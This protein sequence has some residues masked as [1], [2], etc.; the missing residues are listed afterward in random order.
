[1]E[2][3][4]KRQTRSLMHA[5]EAIEAQRDKLKKVNK[6]KNK[7]FSLV[8]HDLKNPLQQM[9]GLLNLLE[10]QML[11]S[12]KGVILTRTMK[13]GL[14]QNITVIERLLQWSYQQ[15]DGIQ[16][17]KEQFDIEELFHEVNHELKL[18]QESKHLTIDAR[19][20][21]TALTADKDMMKVVIRNLLSNAIKFSHEEGHIHVYTKRGKRV[22]LTI[23]DQGIGMNPQWYESLIQSGEPVSTPGTKGEKGKGF[24]LLITK[25]FVEM[26]GGTMACKSEDGSGT[27]FEVSFPA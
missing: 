27:V 11:S 7:L 3:E 17:K 1:L 2:E 15:L 4:V 13:I 19:F 25:D 9:V 26:N 10:N 24:G 21:A 18:A 14:S 8:S 5:K 6:L 20:E 16:V 12:D 23:A 22:V